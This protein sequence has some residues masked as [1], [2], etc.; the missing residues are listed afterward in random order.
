MFYN[1]DNITELDLSSFKTSNVESFYAMFANMDKLTTLDIST[2]DIRCDLMTNMFYHCPM[3]EVIYIGNDWSCS[4]WSNSDNMFAGCTSI[5]GQDGTTYDSSKTNYQVTHANQGGYMSLKTFT[6]TIPESGYAT[7]SCDRNLNVNNDDLTVFV[8]NNYSPVNGTVRMQDFTEHWEPIRIQLSGGNVVEYPVT[9][10]VIPK[11]TGVVVKGTPGTTYYFEVR[12]DWTHQLLVEN[13]LV[14]VT[15]ATH[16]EPTEG[17]YTNFML[18]NGTF[19]R[20]AAAPETSKM[21][22]NRAYLHVLTD[23]LDL[24]DGAAIRIEGIYDDDTPTGVTEI[25]QTVTDFP[26]GVYDLN[27]RKVADDASGIKALPMGIYIINGQKV[28]WR[29]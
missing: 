15:K 27:G 18:K 22:A 3:L 20:I 29:P 1:C 2:F 21:P 5:V 7:F 4:A 23:D 19:I 24:P 13:D 28:N 6:V 11:N 14:A 25:P 10:K 17:D 12:S 8:C 16:V 9:D 26:E